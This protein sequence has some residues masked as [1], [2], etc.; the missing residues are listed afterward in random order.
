MRARA[1]AKRAADLAYTRAYW[2]S[3]HDDLMMEA[4]RLDRE[5]TRALVDSAA[6]GE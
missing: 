6:D 3:M 1:R 2:Q 4:E 5:K